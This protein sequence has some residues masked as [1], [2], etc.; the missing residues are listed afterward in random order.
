MRLNVYLSPISRLIKILTLGG[1]MLLCTLGTAQAS[2]DKADCDNIGCDIALTPYTLSYA[3]TYN[4]MDI[5][6]E[7]QLKLE[8]KRYELTTTA[9]TL[10]SS[11]EEEG[12]FL[13]D[14]KRGIID[15]GYQYKR[16]ILGIKK[17]EKLKYDR[18][19][20]VANYTTKKKKRQVTLETGYLNRLSYQVQLQRDL[21]N[22]V[23]P[24]QYQVISRG[25]LKE[26]NFET[27]GEETLDTPL[28]KIKALKVKRIREDDERETLFWFAP[29]WNY[30]LVQ[31]WQREEGGEDYKIVIQEG[32][33]DKK[34]LTLPKG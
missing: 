34:P 32:S 1:L 22:Q 21:I 23:S 6:A 19:A 11:I 33:L 12:A 4:G 25:R 2:D 9:K 20:G 10:F 15:Q 16:N 17:T 5:S 7:R 29:E 30:L 8:G 27:Q 18:E 13:L 24:L 3:A 26:Y 31:L 14:E 28:G